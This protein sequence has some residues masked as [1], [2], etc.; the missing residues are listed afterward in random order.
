MSSP[1][2]GSRLVCGVLACAAALPGWAA[3]QGRPGVPL[4]SVKLGAVIRV[5]TPEREFKGSL[6]S[7]TPSV[8]EIKPGFDMKTARTPDT[9]WTMLRSQIRDAAVRT[10]SHWRTGA[11]FGAILLGF[12]A[13]ALAG[14]YAY[15]DDE[16]SSPGL[17]MLLGAGSGAVAGGAVGGI[18][19]HF[20]K[21]WAP[22]EGLSFGASVPR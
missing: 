8:V 6:V 16:I 5:R 18:I 12:S 1:C 13:G 17:L 22:L 11:M 20:I 15:G 19:G 14:V 4:D 7:R 2:R 10:G 21:V 9:T 3:A